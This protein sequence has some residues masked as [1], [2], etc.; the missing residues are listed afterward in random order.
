MSAAL[1]AF[2]HVMN[3]KNKKQ[4]ATTKSQLTIAAVLEGRCL[5]WN[6]PALC[7]L[8]LR[9][10]ASCSASGSPHFCIHKMDSILGI[11]QVPAGSGRR[12]APAASSNRVVPQPVPVQ[13]AEVTHCSQLHGLLI[14]TQELESCLLNFLK[15]LQKEEAEKVCFS[16][17]KRSI[18]PTLKGLRNNSLIHCVC[19]IHRRLVFLC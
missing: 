14:S 13:G 16:H 7:F 8:A 3:N 1:P 6:S 9:S 10:R 5:G 17:K 11:W 12:H 2:L 4:L 15:P 19:R 18:S